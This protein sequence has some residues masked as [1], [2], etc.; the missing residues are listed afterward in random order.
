MSSK[1]GRYNMH[2]TNAITHITKHE[3]RCSHI[4]H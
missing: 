2:N 1:T 4:A 3:F